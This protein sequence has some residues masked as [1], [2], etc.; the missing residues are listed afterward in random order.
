MYPHRIRLVGPWHCEPLAPGAVS[1]RVTMPCRW[2]DTELAGFVGRICC[3]RRFGAPRTLDSHERVWLTCAGAEGDVE[4]WLNGTLLSKHTASGPFEYEI[5]PL[6][7]PRN[8]LRM[9][10]ECTDATGGLTG[11]VALEI[12]CTAFLQ[13]SAVAAK[14]AGASGRLQVLGVIAGTA[15]R[16][17]EV[18]ILLDQ[19]TVGYGVF[20]AGGSFELVSDELER[21]AGTHQ[22][23]VDLVNGAVIWHQYEQPFAWPES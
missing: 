20:P 23:R 11:E 2:R 22:V 21:R 9:E 15:D 5:T 17:L 12:R 18:Y 14:I 3:T 6:L 19:A 8:E 10:M 1:A 4:V 7:Q 13:D 16:P